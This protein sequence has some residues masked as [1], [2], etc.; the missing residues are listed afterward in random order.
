MSGAVTAA[1]EA[2]DDLVRQFA[3]P[4]AFFRELVQN[5]V[6]AGSP[7]VEIRFEYAP[8]AGGGAGVMTIHV[9]D[10]GEGMSREIIDN[11]L[12][13]LFSSAKD[14]D[15][16]KIGRFGIGFVSVFALEPDAVCVDTSRGGES[17]RVLFERDRSFS[18][19]ALE[20]PV[21]GT[22]IRVI[23]AVDRATYDATRARARDVVR[24][25]CKHLEP[26]VVFEGEAVNEPLT[27][28]LLGEVRHEE[29]GTVVV[30]AYAPVDASPFFG[31]YNKGLTLLE[32]AEG[33]F[34]DVVFKVSSRYLEHT[35]TRDNVLRDDQHDKAMAIVGRLVEDALPARLVEAIDAA[36]RAND[37]AAL[38]A[39]LALAGAR[40]ALARAER[41]AQAVA[42]AV[43]GALVTL[44][45]AAEA[46][47]KER[48]YVAPR[49]NEVT[50]RLA[51][52]GGAVVVC[53]EGGLLARALAALPGPPVRDAN[54]TWCVARAADDATEDARWAPLRAALGDVLGAWGG[55]LAGVSVAH[56]DGDD[57][58]VAGALAITQRALGELTPVAEARD[59]GRSL[60]SRRR[61]LVVNAD[62]P[63]IEDLIALSAVTPS[64]AGYLAAK[65]FFH[66]G[67]LDPALDAELATAALRRR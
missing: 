54:A 66:D 20:A 44:A 50:R 25:W 63:A 51:A 38:T 65:L 24:Y 1:D 49:G 5:A 37:G 36:T 43:D 46:K 21:D 58:A 34:E 3:D 10:F 26:E 41:G 57:S 6:D 52:E 14:G 56:L 35:L 29:P 27:L 19:I 11:K 40:R 61:W 47:A 2:L 67:A 64:L 31:F 55:K 16:T 53:D 48:L 17:W 13:R 39:S 42:R 15:L 18:R 33:Y 8:G 28:G 30:A 32:G 60:F 59:I 45:V 7:A 9:D 4:L 12:T 23:K 62:H 22:K